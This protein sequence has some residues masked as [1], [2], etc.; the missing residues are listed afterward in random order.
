MFGR[1][2]HFSIARKR[3]SKMD[4]AL[5]MLERATKKSPAKAESRQLLSELGKRRAQLAVTVDQMAAHIAKAEVR[6]KKLGAAGTVSWSAFQTAL[7]KSHKAF[8]RA[9]HKAAKA[10]KRSIR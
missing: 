6:M 9:N 5:A 1:D 10:I 3:I 4:S 7:T 8:A 2:G